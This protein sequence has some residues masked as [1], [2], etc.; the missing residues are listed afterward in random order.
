MLT[1]LCIHNLGKLWKY[2]LGIYKNILETQW[3]YNLNI[4][5]NI[6]HR[7]SYTLSISSLVILNR[8]IILRV[9]IIYIFF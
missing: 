9:N 3:I 8:S 7:V 6:L 2:I 1:V 4:Y 5:R